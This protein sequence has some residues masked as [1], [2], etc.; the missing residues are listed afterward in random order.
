MDAESSFAAF[1]AAYPRK[2]GKGDAEKVWAKLKVSQSL[3]VQILDALQK[4]K[5]TEQ[6]RRDSGQF[7][8]H[9]ATWLRQGRFRDEGMDAGEETAA[10]AIR[11]SMDGLGHRLTE[12]GLQFWV[13]VIGEYSPLAIR[14]AFRA[15]SPTYAG[16]RPSPHDI[17]VLLANR[18]APQNVRPINLHRGSAGTLARRIAHL[19]GWGEAEKAM[20]M[21]YPGQGVQ[22]VRDL[23]R[24]GVPTLAPGPIIETPVETPNFRE[25]GCDDD[26]E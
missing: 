17:K 20:E 14:E 6:W 5:A 7:V 18:E 16:S 11:G 4:A 21:A 8:P 24:A 19:R 23:Q 22:F 15:F 10:S 13:A 9:P 12:D 1:W 2:V 25:P 26:L 3:L